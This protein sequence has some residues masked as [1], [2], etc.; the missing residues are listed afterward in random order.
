VDLGGAWIH[1]PVGNPLTAWADQVGAIRR[2]ADF[3]PVSAGWDPA[4]GR[5]PAGSYERVR[6][7]VMEDYFDAIPRLT[8]ELGP[9]AT[10]R[11]AIDR[12]TTWPEARVETAAEAAWLHSLLC[13]MTEQDGGASLD[14]VALRGFP[15]AQL[16][17]DGNYLG[18]FV[19]GG[20]RRLLT[21]LAAGLDIRTGTRVTRIRVTP[22]GVEVTTADGGRLVA[23]HALVTVP[24]GVL[25]AGDI[26]FEPPLERDR[27]RAIGA[28]GMGRFEKLALRF[29]R[30]FW[31]EA[32]LPHVM[33]MPSDGRTV[34]Q[35][36]V[37]LDGITGDPVL[38]VLGIAAAAAALSD[39]D[40]RD[41]VGRI[42]DDLALMTGRHATPVA[43]VRSS[44]ARDPL[45]R[46]SYAYLGLRA[47]PGDA[48]IL[49][50]P[51]AGRVLFA[52]EATSAARMGYADGAFSTGIR[53]AKRLLGVSSVVLGPLAP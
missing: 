43:V 9:T 14:A 21:P 42:V 39:G 8:A 22:D 51:L 2:P 36:I 23:D 48:D 49:A 29:E 3:L 53:E 5:I 30:P 50:A 10:M 34:P 15:A 31:T 17:Y 37:G 7:I 18:D 38:V 16:E 4:T 26:A 11:E 12:F 52:G 46:G 44:W 25:K 47:G 6:R 19:D 24:L 33:V 28:L 45:T 27:T 41:A 40:E 13:T 20:Y 32:G 35:A 1:T